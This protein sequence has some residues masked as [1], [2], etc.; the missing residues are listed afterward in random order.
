MTVYYGLML[1]GSGTIRGIRTLD[2]DDDL[3]AVDTARDALLKVRQYDAAEVW[4]HGVKVG[5][6]LRPVSSLP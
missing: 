2:C 1:D 3:A 4:R 6:V 5:K